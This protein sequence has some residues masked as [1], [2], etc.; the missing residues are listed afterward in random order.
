MNPQETWDVMQEHRRC[1][2]NEDAPSIRLVCGRDWYRGPRHY[3]LGVYWGRDRDAAIGE[4]LYRRRLVLRWQFSF[5][6][7]ASVRS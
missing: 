3:E 6:F 1:A 5:N 4:E 2:R 7:D